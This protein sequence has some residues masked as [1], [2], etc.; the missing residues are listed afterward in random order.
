M[1]KEV[2][3]FS[4]PAKVMVLKH[5]L[6][7]RISQKKKIRPK[8]SMEIQGFDQCMIP[9]KRAKNPYFPGVIKLPILGGIKDCKSMVFLRDF[10][11]NDALFGMVI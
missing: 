10:P 6:Q 1:D 3:T 11:Y 4:S 8:G 7:L 2:T 9:I 5:T